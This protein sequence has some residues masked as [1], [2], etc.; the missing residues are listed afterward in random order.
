MLDLSE[1][2][3]SQLKERFEAVS[4][5]FSALDAYNTDE[6]EPLVT[7]LES[8]NILREDVSSKFMPRGELLANAPEQHDGYFQVPAAIE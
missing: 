4:G 8:H 3:R 2:E 7:V 6:V 1:S 5:G